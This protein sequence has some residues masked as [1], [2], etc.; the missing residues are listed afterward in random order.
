[1]GGVIRQEALERI[2]RHDQVLDPSQLVVGATESESGLG[3][4]RAGGV[5]AQKSIEGVDRIAPFPGDQSILAL[6]E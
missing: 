2:D 1:M 3:Q 4:I 6:L 5:I